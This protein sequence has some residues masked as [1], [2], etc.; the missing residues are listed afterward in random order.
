[1]STGPDTAG[2]HS[3]FSRSPIDSPGISVTENEEM[4]A[5]PPPPPTGGSGLGPRPPEFENPVRAARYRIC[6]DPGHPSEV[7][8]GTR[9]KRITEIEAVWQVAQKLK[10]RLEQDGMQVELTKTRQE[11]F[12]PKPGQ[13]SNCQPYAG[14]SA[15]AVTLRRNYR[16]RCGDFRPRSPG[17][18]QRRTWPEPD[19]D[20][21]QSTVGT[22]VPR[23]DGSGSGWRAAG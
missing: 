20:C 18:Q 19:S 9:G 7:G 4:P 5:E 23:G 11:E 21:S 1:M 14:P 13:G 16:F 17:C 10:D 3:S 6:I 22:A 15:R 12:V 8:R 2:R